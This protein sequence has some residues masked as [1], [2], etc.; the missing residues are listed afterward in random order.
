MLRRL[1]FLFLMIVTLGAPAARTQERGTAQA[2]RVHGDVQ[3]GGEWQTVAPESVG[4]SSAKLEALRAWLKTQDTT[5]MMV[6]VQGRVIFAYGDVAHASKI[7]SVR[8]SILSM[9]YGK[10]VLN[11]TINL[12]KTVVE[13]GLQEKIPFLP[14][15]E[16]RD[17]GATDGCAFRA[18]TCRREAGDS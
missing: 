7:A 4:F 13:L 6:V 3:P 17:A 10:Y 9:L 8:K 14:I 2:Q 1:P 18:S 5:S 12:E 16:T 15:E 11:G